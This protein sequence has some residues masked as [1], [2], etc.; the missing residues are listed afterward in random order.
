M[1][2]TRLKKIK[3]LKMNEDIYANSGIITDNTSTHSDNSN[4]YEDIYDNE[5]VPE[6]DVTRSHKETMTSAGSRY[7]RLAAVCLGLLCVLLLTGITVLWIKFN[8]L[9]IERDQLQTSYTS[10][11]MERDQ[12]KTSYI[13]LTTERD[14]LQ[15]SYTS[16]TIERDQIQTN[17]DNMKNEMGQLQKEKET[18]QKK[19]SLLEQNQR[20]FQNRFYYISTNKKSWS[21]SKQVCKAGGADLVIINSRAEQEFISKAFG[22]SEAWIGLT[23]SHTEGDWKWVDNS[24]LTT[25]FW[26]TGEPNDYDG[27]EDCA[28]TGYKGAG[29]ERLST[30]ADYPCDHPVVGLCE[31]SLTE[32]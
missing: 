12:L 10:L 7:Y 9:T 11:T 23:D 5:D 8:N 17:N 28:I 30:W 4:D 2:S 20:C 3:E 22:S 13:S 32:F 19:L 6:T 26:W 18:L 31:K 27:N 24:A 14:Q 1:A 15:T 29:S 21:E 16:L 25:E